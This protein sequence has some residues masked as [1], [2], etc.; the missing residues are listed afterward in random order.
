MIEFQH[1]G[2]RFQV[3]ELPTLNRV[4][5]WMLDRRCAGVG[6]GPR[7]GHSRR[8]YREVRSGDDE[9][10]HHRRDRPRRVQPP[11]PRL[12][13]DSSTGTSDQY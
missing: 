4:Q 5:L 9:A 12:A 2:I 8:S 10:L 3:I 1:G 7:Q 13:D 6:G 11:T